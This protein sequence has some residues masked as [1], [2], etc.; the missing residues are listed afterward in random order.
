MIAQIVAAT[1]ARADQLYF[2]AAHSGAE[3]DLLLVRGTERV[4]FEIKRTT[5]PRITT[6]TRSAISTLKLDRAYLVHAGESSFLLSEGVEALA[7]REL[8]ARAD[9]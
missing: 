1:R 4:G 9:L 2:W 5:G 3:L 6:G 7:A 8:A